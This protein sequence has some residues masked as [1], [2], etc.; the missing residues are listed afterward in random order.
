MRLIEY[1]YKGVYAYN[2]KISIWIMKAYLV[3]YKQY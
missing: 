2:I 1:D 3:I